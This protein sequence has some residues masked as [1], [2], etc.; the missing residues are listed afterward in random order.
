MT[1]KF[2]SLSLFKKNDVYYFKKNE[3][4]DLFIRTFNFFDKR[5]LKNFH[6]HND[7]FIFK[8]IEYC[9]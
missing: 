8:R 5:I 2:L 6:F 4:L 3:E 9:C 7:E 1:F